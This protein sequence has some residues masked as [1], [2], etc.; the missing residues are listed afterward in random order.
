MIILFKYGAVIVFSQVGGLVV[1]LIWPRI[2][3]L[4]ERWP[5]TESSNS[6]EQFLVVP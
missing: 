2:I 1:K 4:S 6:S 5:E 3:S